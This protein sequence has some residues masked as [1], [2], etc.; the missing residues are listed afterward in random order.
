MA[1]PEKEQEQIIAKESLLKEINEN[2]LSPMK[3]YQKFFVG[4]TG[5][6]DL[7]KYELITML[8]GGMPG[9]LG[10]ALRKALYPTLFQHCGSGVVWGRN[11]SLRNPKR[12]RVGDG[13]AIDDNVLLDAKG[14][15]EGVQIGADCIIARDTLIQAKTAPVKIGDHCTLG[16]QCQ[17]SSAGGIELGNYVMLAGQCYLGGGRYKTDDMDIPMKK[18]ALYTK[19]PTII[20]DDVWVGSGVVIQ[21][22]VRIGRGSVIGSGAT[23]RED[24]PEYTVVVPHHRLVMLP[25]NQE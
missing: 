5:F 1:T 18:Q 4:S 16:S 11:V 20:E 7:I 2:E 22:G 23:V 12:I 25:R 9:A 24:I 8:L 21:D 19:G 13:T 17:L 6:G 15:E 10:L 3:R 14:H